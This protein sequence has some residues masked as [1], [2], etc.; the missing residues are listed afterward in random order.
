MERAL[1]ELSPPTRWL[2]KRIDLYRELDSTNRLAE[3]LAARG[4]PEGTLVVAD[5]QSA[6]RGR[7]GRSFFS[8][9]G[10]SIYLSALLRP[11]I[12]PDR[13]HRYVFVAAHA[14]AACVQAHLPPD[15]SVEI[16]WPNDVLVGG[17]KVSGINLPCRIEAGRVTALILGIGVNVNLEEREFP[18]ELRDLATSLRI[19]AGRPL[20]RVSF[21]EALVARLERE[22][23]RFR[24]EGFEPVLEAWKKFFRMRGSR[25]RVGGPGVAREAEGLVLGVDADG[26]LLLRTGTTIERILAGD[27][28]LLGRGR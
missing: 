14:V 4:A 21:A 15:V 11:E 6:G 17:R 10:R 1:F 2:G 3:D 16:K 19:A 9:P 26:A 7:L 22:I 24:A 23:E 18:P 25:V 8:P 13:T 5:G 12:E 28:T 27:V 20:D